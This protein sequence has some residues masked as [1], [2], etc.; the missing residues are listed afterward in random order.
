MII[1]HCLKWSILLETSFAKDFWSS[2]NKSNKNVLVAW[3]TLGI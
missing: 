2:I 3:K 1:L